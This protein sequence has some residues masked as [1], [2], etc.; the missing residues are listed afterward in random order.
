M[1]RRPKN[2]D[3]RY[4]RILDAWQAPQGAGLPIGCVATTFTFEAAFFEEECLGRFL[5]L[6]TNLAEDGLGYIWEREDKMT[7]VP[8]IVLADHRHADPVRSARWDLL[9]VRVPGAAQHAKLSVLA[10]QHLVR[11]IVASANLTEPGYR[12]NL[13]VFAVVDLA[14]GSGHD[15]AVMDQVVAFLRGIDGAYLAGSA[16]PPGP[17]R[18]L[19]DLLGRLTKLAASFASGSPGAVRTRLVL[20]GDWAGTRHVALDALAELIPAGAG[21]P[22]EAVVVSPF[23]DQERGDAAEAL[24]RLMLTRA[25][26][27]VQ[28]VAPGIEQPDKRVRLRVP[29]WF[30]SGSAG[31]AAR[32][33]PETPARA[34]EGP[35]PS[36]GLFGG[37]EVEFH[38]A[39]ATVND[40]VRPLHAKMLHLARDGAYR[41]VMIGSSNF[42]RAGLGLGHARAPVNLEANVAFVARDG[43]GGT[44]ELAR[45]VPDV[46]G[47]LDPTRIIFDPQPD[48]DDA[49]ALPP[50]PLFFADALFDPTAGQ[51]KACLRFTGV[52]PADWVLKTPGGALLLDADGWQARGTP[53]ALDVPWP[54][55]APAAFLSVTWVAGDER[56]EGRWTVNLTDPA[57]LPSADELRQLP[58]ATLLEMLTSA[59]PPHETL[60]QIL[61]A[62]ARHER[63]AADVELDPLR[64]Y[65]DETA[66]LYRTRRVARALEEMRQK[67]QRPVVSEETFRWRLFESPIG[68]LRLAEA[69]A[70]EARTPA[71]AAFLVA[72]V[73][74]IVQDVEPP[75]EPGS[76][77]RAAIRR[78]LS[79]CAGRVAEIAQG[80][81]AAG[82]VGP[83]VGYIEQVL[84]RSGA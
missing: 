13:E 7:G 38:R 78:A 31:K 56:F 14:D 27:R 76:P 54:D 3:A 60:R 73:V 17:R 69:L 20:G 55:A 53:E 5:G 61:R 80:R 81:L 75:Q 19:N 26:R 39:L 57:L 50:L 9:P 51:R 24:A 68:P 25:G 70:R 43:N 82:E 62:Q 74:L 30:A 11:I 59:R 64:R 34:D 77:P 29:G 35:S 46:D 22:D 58:L 72:E 71:E 6:Q 16:D 10:W 36:G 42:T 12:S 32:G 2:G 40:E 65:R 23:F 63:A 52:G 15:P 49:S 47:P 8:M 83:L 18:R 4:S 21:K 66:L 45:L 41:V 84:A 28:I 44:A 48:P 1:S 79:D 37:A 33:G 67:L